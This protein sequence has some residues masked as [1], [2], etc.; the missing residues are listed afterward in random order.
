MSVCVH[1]YMYVCIH[2]RAF[3]LFPFVCVAGSRLKQHFCEIYSFSPVK[4]MLYCDVLNF[5]WNGEDHKAS[6]LIRCSKKVQSLNSK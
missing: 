5:N 2:I 6:S 4:S 3:W 1:I